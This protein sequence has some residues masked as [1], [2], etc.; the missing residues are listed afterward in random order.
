MK[1]WLYQAKEAKSSLWAIVRSMCSRQ[2]NRWGCGYPFATFCNGG[3]LSHGVIGNRTKWPGATTSKS[4]VS[5]AWSQATKRRGAVIMRLGCRGLFLLGEADVLSLKGN[6]LFNKVIALCTLGQPELRSRSI[7]KKL[8]IRED[9][10][11]TISNFKS[12]QS[13]GISAKETL[14]WTSSGPSRG[15][16]RRCPATR[17][18]WG[19]RG[20]PWT[21]RTV[22]SLQVWSSETQEVRVSGNTLEDWFD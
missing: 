20:V 19:A 17:G 16:F 15:Y 21:W 9:T 10:L 5:L 6:A 14:A 13:L 7:D 22:G 3:S 18:H 1:S 8:P 2:R 4:Y 11:R 12:R